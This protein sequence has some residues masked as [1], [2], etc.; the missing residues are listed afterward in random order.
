MTM[1]IDVLLYILYIFVHTL[2]KLIEHR[3]GNTSG[4]SREHTVHKIHVFSFSYKKR[5]KQHG[6][7]FNTIMKCLIKTI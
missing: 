4:Q 3:S 5:W 7:K 1:V 2:D 6:W